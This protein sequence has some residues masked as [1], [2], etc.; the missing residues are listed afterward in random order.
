METE[1]PYDEID[2]L[3]GEYTHKQDRLRRQIEDMGYGDGAP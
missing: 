1:C 3:T 2:W